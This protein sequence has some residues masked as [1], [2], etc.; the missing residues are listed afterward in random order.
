MM[1]KIGWIIMVLLSVGCLAHAQQDYAVAQIA[2]SL[3]SRANAVVR[4]QHIVVDMLAP[5]KVRYHVKEAITVF[6]K[7]GERKARMVIY[8]DKSTAI[9]RVSGRVF[10]ADGFQIGKFS[11]KDFSDE[12]AVSSY[13]LYEDSRVKHFLP[14]VTSYPYTVEYDCEI[15]R[16][17]NLIIPDW[18][19][20]T[21]RDVAVEE[22]QYTFMCGASDAVRTKSINYAG[23][24][25]VGSLDGRTTRTWKVSTIPAQ[26]HEPYSPDPET[27][28]TIVRIAPVDFVYY[29]HKGSYS[30]WQ[31]LGKWMHHALLT[32]GSALPAGTVQEVRSL[33][34]GVETDQEKARVLYEYMQRKTRYISVQIGIGGFKPMAAS[35]VDRLGYGDCKALVNYM[36]ALLMV[37]DI[38]SY[39]C[40]VNAG[41]AKRDIQP[42]F[43][44][45]DQGNH[46]ILCL[47]FEKD[48]IWL[49]CT[50]QRVP[51]G[52]LGSFT[53]DRTVW[54]CTPEG[55]QLLRTP[56]FDEAESSQI[57]H[58][59]LVLDGDGNLSGKV[60]T[61][62]AAGQYDNH[63]EIAESSG[64]EQ[65]KLLKETYDIDHI[66]FRNIDY[67]KS[68]AERPTLVEAFD[69]TLAKYAPE[70]NRQIFMVANVFNR[71][72]TIPTIKNRILPVYINRGYTD[73]DYIVYTLP[74]NYVMVSPSFDEV[75]ETPFGYYHAILS[76]DGD[77]MT[78]H[79]KFI[80]NEGTF[81]AEQYIEF[82]A[83]INRV[84][85]LDQYKAVLA[86]E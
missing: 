32:E 46:I 20:N 13:S 64:M 58:A 48:T 30:N 7:G 65:L 52:F 9:K 66:G 71:R 76:Q 77:R 53:D 60:E 41:S 11:H 69:V 84:S 81:P 49:E 28:Q 1:A 74:A 4:H 70:N 17:Q 26:R 73:E 37:V 86:K 25:I 31:E 59:E 62:F 23:E 51:F 29:K 15:E 5:T 18:R 61:M 34:E 83:F 45:M 10:D 22:S 82:S 43:A 56:R 72:G 47:P 36:Q 78:Y 8:Y 55:G 79:R 12:S 19:P 2:D 57:R 16:K 3:K 54:A 39:Y 63:L 38:P 14:S 80:L 33:V 27:Y 44:E 6:N 35:E 75:I 40:V 50:N 24:P 42:D 21:S 68:N 85:M 67:Q